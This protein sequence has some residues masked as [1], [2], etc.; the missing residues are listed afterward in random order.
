MA[1]TQTA[2]FEVLRLG[3]PYNQLLSPL[4]Q[5]IAQSGNYEVRDFRVPWEHKDFLDLLAGLRYRESHAGR[6]DDSL[7]KLGGALGE[8]LD[9]V[10]GVVKA[11]N[12]AD[13]RTLLNL[14]V[15]VSAGELAQLPFEAAHRPN[16]CAG[17]QTWLS[18]Q[19]DR[20]VA[21][22]RRV[23]TVSTDRLRW[24][25]RPR[26][27]MVAAQ[28]GSL[29]VP[30]RSHVKALSDAVQPFVRRGDNDTEYLKEVSKVLKVLP[31]AS[32]E[33]IRDTCATADPPFT[34]VHVLAHGAPT[35]SGSYGLLLEKSTGQETVSGDRFAAAL[36]DR[37]GDLPAIV[38][39]AACDSGNVG[40]VVYSGASFAHEL[41]QAQIPFVV[42]SQLPLTFKGSER[43]VRSLYEPLLWGQDPRP[44]LYGLRQ[45]L[46][47]LDSVKSHDWASIVCYAALP[48]RFDAE[49]DKTRYQQAKKASSAALDRFDTAIEGGREDDFS[50]ALE[51]VDRA[52]RH[53][54]KSPAY[55]TE[56]L[57]RQGAA[58]KRKSEAYSKRAR[59]AKKAADRDTHHHKMLDHLAQASRFYRNAADEA[60]RAGTDTA[61]FKVQIHWVLAQHLALEVCLGNAL[62]ED[63]WVVA[64]E[65]ARVYLDDPAERTWANG[66]LAELYMLRPT[67]YRD[68]SLAAAQLVTDHTTP[69]D[70]ERYSTVRQ[71]RRYVDW[72]GGADF[73]KA[74]KLKSKTRDEWDT[75][76]DLAREIDGVL[77]GDETQR[78][79]L[80]Q[81]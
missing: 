11:V 67:E 13:G 38:T 64:K 69:E 41:H 27:L 30:L 10:P 50:E 51:A 29:T 43:M 33:Q 63:K 5:Y 22:T 81:T 65:S 4:T 54:P 70:F 55:T 59:S 17:A 77:E 48:S 56:V 2:S 9:R 45:Q 36:R 76:I 72:W 44:A 32:M 46:F 79:R 16:S 3:P 74:L 26:I 15:V 1:E 75:L 39:V 66:T 31:A 14:E 53:M 21:I 49:L 19:G 68:A 8:M 73:K 35:T 78:V 40:D 57:G 62:D 52:M 60:M 71:F 25:T 12:C 23:R 20:R 7:E 37:N 24:P 47:A 34:N 58:E 80:S 42:A 28:P 6:R 61:V 18:I